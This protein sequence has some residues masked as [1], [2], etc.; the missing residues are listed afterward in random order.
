[1]KRFFSFFLVLLNCLFVFGCYF[2]EFSSS[3]R[4]RLIKGG[5]KIFKEYLAKT[6][7]DA[8]ITEMKD[9]HYMGE[10]HQ[11]QLTEFAEGTYQSGTKKFRFAVNT[12][13]GEIYTSEKEEEFRQKL[14]TYVNELLN[15]KWNVVKSDICFISL[16]NAHGKKP[17]IDKRPVGLNGVLPVNIPDM[18]AYVKTALENKNLVLSLNFTFTGKPLN[19]EEAFL[20]AAK[21]F[22]NNVSVELYRLPDSLLKELESSA[23]DSIRGLPYN[24]PVFLAEETAILQNIGGSTDCIFKKWQNFSGAAPFTLHYAAKIQ[25]IIKQEGSHVKNETVM[26]V[27]EQELNIKQN[28]QQFEFTTK[29]NKKLEFYIFINQLNDVD[30]VNEVAL[31]NRKF[32]NAPFNKVLWH[33]VLNRWSIGPKYEKSNTIYK[34]N[35]NELIVV[36]KPALDKLK[37]AK[38]TGKQDKN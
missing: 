4:A 34:L 1:M 24:R 36:G 26:F 10:N 27:P 35:E 21:K 12:N 5:E 11:F 17:P 28:G 14:T 29:N 6:I 19:P 13:T 15:I 7:P 37:P 18:D 38:D 3:D 16:V 20:T 31:R 2:D 32:H 30:N 22:S 23:L 9:V 25:H 8:K 33:P